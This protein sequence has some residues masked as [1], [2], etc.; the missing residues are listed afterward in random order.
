MNMKEITLFVNAWLIVNFSDKTVQC[1]ISL[2][3]A[4]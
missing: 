2:I 4:E 3:I 1:A